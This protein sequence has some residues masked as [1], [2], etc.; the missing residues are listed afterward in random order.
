MIENSVTQHVQG[1]H[2]WMMIN[3]TGFA[4]YRARELELL[5]FGL[6]MEQT[7]ILHILLENGGSL[8]ITDFFTEL[9][10]RPNS[11]YTLLDRM[12]HIGL[13]TKEKE[14]DSRKTLVKISEKGAR[15][16]ESLTNKTLELAFSPLSRQQKK[17]LSTMLIKTTIRARELL[18]YPNEPPV[19]QYRQ[20]HN[21]GKPPSILLN[22]LEDLPES[23]QWAIL[24]NTR[25]TINHARQMELGR[26]G[27]TVEQ[28][29]LLYILTRE[30]KPVSINDIINETMRQPASVYSL[31]NRMSKK[32]IVKIKKPDYSTVS[33]VS[34]S[35]TGQK[36]F[37]TV[38]NKS[39]E[40][41]FS[42][43]SIQQKEQLYELLD[44][45]NH[46]L[47]NILGINYIPPDE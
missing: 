21:I 31:I 30:E 3:T 15:L 16:F 42:E 9:H 13:V 5:Q 12:A 24:N 47:R 22:T 18:G 11:I 37:E 32:K 46:H 36:L 43:L 40:Y 19:Q 20:G 8:L 26:S 45:L 6:T 34:I 10:R 41:I 2:L 38:T 28:F 33:S 7:T 4:I 35:P 14:P 17:L 44:I 23:K 25:F 27:F 29:M 39:L 1:T